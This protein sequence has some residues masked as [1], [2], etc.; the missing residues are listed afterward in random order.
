MI[1]LLA[2]LVVLSLVMMVA[3]WW[4]RLVSNAGWVDAFWTFGIGL[5]GAVAAV[6]AGI[7][8]RHWLVAGVVAAWAL[9]LGTY[10]ALRSRKGPEDTRYAKFRQDWGAA[11]QRRMFVFLQL[12][13]LAA[14][15]LLLPIVAAAKSPRLLG[16]P[17]AVAVLLVLVAVVG[18]GQA[19]Q[20]MHAFRRANHGKVCDV[21]LWGLS[22][23]PNY[24]FE[25]LYWCA[26]PI[27]A[28][29]SDWAWPALAGPAMMYWLLVH[30]SGIPPL[31][32]QLL[33]SRGDAYRLYQRRV[34]AFFPIPH[35]APDGD[36]A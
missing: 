15:I 11:F 24:F 18:E 5:V 1:V 36:R 3:W 20:Q 26:Y 12:Q 23:H 33:R 25:W 2:G 13:A 7:G 31:E 17:D 16:W 34:R 32:A 29:G 27:F 8:P 9:R 35:R 30:V 14:A 6:T 28:I 22:R 10:I 19:D 4:Q 21:G